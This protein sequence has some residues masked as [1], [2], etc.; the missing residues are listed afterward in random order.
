MGNELVARLHL[1]DPGIESDFKKATIGKDPGYK[2]GVDFADLVF[3]RVMKD[4]VIR[5]K[6]AEA[7]VLLIEN[8]V[9][10]EAARQRLIDRLSTNE[11]GLAAERGATQLKK[12]SKE[13]NL[14]NSAL[15]LHV[16]RDVTF[17]SPGTLHWYRPLHYSAIRQL[18]ESG[19]IT[20]WSMD[21]ARLTDYVKF[22]LSAEYLHVPNAFIVEKDRLMDRVTIV[23]EATHAIQDWRDFVADVKLLEA[24]AYIA[25]AMVA[26]DLQPPF[27]SSE[28]KWAINGDLV[29]MVLN[30]EAIQGNKKWEAIYKD[31]VSQVM[32][33][34]IYGKKAMN[35]VTRKEF[36]PG[37]ERLILR[38]KHGTNEKEQMEKLKHAL[39]KT[40]PY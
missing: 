2:L 8:H 31:M 12:G 16:V 34:P 18:V 19:S 40:Y 5:T 10:S 21:A 35:P 7:L 15:D 9:F 20:V 30:N 13:L 24:D 36:I 14:F 17:W 27:L 11:A 23:H 38:E 4:S 32:M 37:D 22:G 39:N 6:E 28:A 33:D 26:N 1:L 3:E 29:D 25:E